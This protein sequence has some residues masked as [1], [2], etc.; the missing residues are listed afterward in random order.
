MAGDHPRRRPADDAYRGAIAGLLA[1]RHPHFAGR[2]VRA[3]VRG[4]ALAHVSNNLL[5]DLFDTKRRLDTKITRGRST[6]PHPIL[7][8]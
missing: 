8:G 7:S 2:L 4:I 1:V 6:A 3:R 5:N